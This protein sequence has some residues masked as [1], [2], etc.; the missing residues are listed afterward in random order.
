MYHNNFTD[1]ITGIRKMEKLTKIH[2]LKV[3]ETE[4][5][6]RLQFVGSF[7]YHITMW[8]KHFLLDYKWYMLCFKIE[9]H[10]LRKSV[11]V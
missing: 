8:Y 11:E 7:F 9:S 4:I 2:M 5:E 3:R 6:L 1:K 10:E